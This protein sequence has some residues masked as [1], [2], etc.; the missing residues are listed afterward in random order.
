MERMILKAVAKEP[1]DRFPDM[2]AF[3]VAVRAAAGLPPAIPIPS[4]AA[5]HGAAVP[6]PA[7]PE[8]GEE[9]PTQQSDTVSLPPVI[10]PVAPPPA[11]RARGWP[12]AP[13]P[14]LALGGAVVL[15][16][17]LVAAAFAIVRSRGAGAEKPI[18]IRVVAPAGA[19]LPA[20]QLGTTGKTRVRTVTPTGSTAQLSLLP[21]RYVLTVSDT[22]VYLD[23]A[24]ITVRAGT[25]QTIHL[26]ALYG[27]LTLQP[28]TGRIAVPG[29][30]L[31]DAP[32][33][34]DLHGVDSAQAAQGIYVRPGR[35]SVSPWPGEYTSPLTVT[36]RA[37]HRTTLNL[38]HFYGRLTVVQLAGAPPS[39]FDLLD[40]RT[41]RAR[42][43]VDAV[44]G[45]QG[46]FVPVGRYQVHFYY[47]DVYPDLL[48]VTIA[49][50]APSHVDLNALFTTV[51]TPAVS[52]NYGVTYSWRQGSVTQTL[53]AQTK[54]RTYYIRAGTYRLEV[55]AQGSTRVVTLHAPLG[56]VTTLPIQ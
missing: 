2:A 50:D 38:A 11:S 23:P 39:G 5:D 49:P 7:V 43:G 4:E 44:Q 46:V 52:T 31:K 18:A 9:A 36:I 26:D 53:Q 8:P 34:R 12:V 27:H 16:L 20:F 25:P 30:E 13:R 48:G 19:T 14:F 32:S 54:A 3:A 24:V 33:G 56:K 10:R 22:T 41:G 47:S 28:A 37:G 15:L 55:A 1:S 29:F 45:R 51:R 35:Y 40:P 42:T 6:I 21:G 17:A